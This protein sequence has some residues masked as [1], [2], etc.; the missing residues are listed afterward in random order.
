MGDGNLH[1]LLRANDAI[2]LEG[3][4]KK[5]GNIF[6]TLE[7]FCCCC[8][9]G[10]QSRKCPAPPEV[11]RDWCS[12]SLNV[13]AGQ[14]SGWSPPQL[15]T[16]WLHVIQGDTCT[17]CCHLPDA[18]N[19]VQKLCPSTRKQVHIWGWKLDRGKKT[20]YR[21]WN[22]AIP[23]RESRS[24]RE[25][26][27]FNFSHPSLIFHLVNSFK[28][29]MSTNSIPI[30]HK[31]LWWW[32]HCHRPVLEQLY[33]VVAPYVAVGACHTMWPIWNSVTVC[34]SVTSVEPNLRCAQQWEWQ[35]YNIYCRLQELIRDISPPKYQTTPARHPKPIKV[36]KHSVTFP[37]I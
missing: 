34:Q 1:L 26:Q 8:W 10:S 28:A 19:V 31:Q 9:H 21:F 2:C 30:G 27:T 5:T 37:V 24:I 32:W 20:K 23:K 25:Y 17:K 22:K 36:S 3:K 12:D 33:G 13:T 35:P 14:F 16:R 7:V 18:R 29:E 6:A 4:K 15:A 11:V